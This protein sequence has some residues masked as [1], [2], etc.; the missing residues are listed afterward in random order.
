MKNVIPFSDLG[1]YN[2]SNSF[3]WTALTFNAKD[4]PEIE[5]WLKEI[6]FMPADASITAMKKIGGNVKGSKGRSDV[7]FI[8]TETTFHPMVRLQVDGLKWTSDFRD[9]Y[10]K[11]YGVPELVAVEDDDAD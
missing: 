5:K 11:D 4:K 7:L 2:D 3:V 1:Q 6:K 9:N 10:G 8:T